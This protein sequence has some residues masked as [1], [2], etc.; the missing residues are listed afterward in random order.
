MQNQQ[1]QDNFYQRQFP[2]QQQQRSSFPTFLPDTT[3]MSSY[4]NQFQNKPPPTRNFQPIFNQQ[5][6]QHNQRLHAVVII[7]IIIIC[8]IIY[9]VVAI[10]VVAQV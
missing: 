5:Q 2:Y 6:Q 7:I 3:N 4:Q 1:Q 8:I 10:I 9:L